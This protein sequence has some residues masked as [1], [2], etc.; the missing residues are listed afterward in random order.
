MA[1]NA[2]VPRGA[3]TASEP[4][5]GEVLLAEGIIDQEQLSRALDAQRSTAAPLG[6]VLVNQ[7]AIHE[8]RL[9]AILSVLLD[10]PVA[11]GRQRVNSI[12]SADRF[13]KEQDGFFHRVRGAYL[14]RAQKFPQRIRLIDSSQSLDKVKESLEIIISS[15]C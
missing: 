14:E 12:K 8:D 1:V 9:T 13:E 6:T 3:P 11:L 7:G 2:D 15:I 10:V 5:L 4:R